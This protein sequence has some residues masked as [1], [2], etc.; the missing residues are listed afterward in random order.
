MMRHKIE[1]FRV[2]FDNS[3]V[4][5]CVL[6]MLRD[7]NNEPCD[8][9]F[10][11]LNRALAELEGVAY[12][13]L[14]GHRFYEVFKNADRK[15]L[16]FYAQAACGG[17]THSMKDYSPEIK[18]YLTVLSYPVREDYCAS[19]LSDDTAYE[20]HLEH[21]NER[22]AFIINDS[23]IYPFECDLITNTLYN[24]K[25]TAKIEG[26]A[27]TV[28][29]FPEAF[30]ARY[31]HPDSAA[32]YRRLYEDMKNGL[33]FSQA[34]I[35]YVFGSKEDTMI[36]R[37]RNSFDRA[38]RPVR[39]YGTAQSISAITEMDRQY[40]IALRQHHINS[41]VID[42]K[43]NIITSGAAVSSDTNGDCIPTPDSLEALGIKWGILRDDRQ[44]FIEAYKRLLNG[45]NNV[46]IRLRR[47]KDESD[48]IDWY[49]IYFDAV[50]DEDG[51]LSKVYASS[52]NINRQ[53]ENE[54]NYAEFEN[55][56]RI[57]TKNTIA[58]I[59][60]NL[61]ANT[62]YQSFAGDSA[63]LYDGT[64]GSA[65]E[66]FEYVNRIAGH[67]LQ[68]RFSRAAMLELYTKGFTARENEMLFQFG[69]SGRRFVRAVTELMENPYTHEVEALMYAIDINRE[70]R[71]QTVMD[72]LVQSDYEFIGIL[73]TTDGLLTIIGKDS[74]K[75]GTGT[76]NAV[77]DYNEN[78]PK[79][80]DW[81][82]RSEEREQAYA[83]LR[84]ENVLEK[85]ELERSYSCAFLGRSQSG[86][87][88]IMW[89]FMYLDEDRK[90]VMITRQDIT[91]AFKL[92]NEQHERL[93]RA[94]DEAQRATRAKTEF[95]SRMS[96][97]IRTPMNAI[98]NLADLAKDDISNQAKLRSDLDKIRL[99]GDFLLGL[100]NDILDMSRIENGKLT[101]TPCVYPVE[102]F[103]GYMESVMTPLFAARN[104]NFV[105]IK[106]NVIPALY[107]DE[108]RF[109]QVF[110]NL[111]S[112]AAKYT[113]EGGTVTFRVNPVKFDEK[114]Y[115][116]QYIVAD[117]GIG[118][119]R[120]FLERAFQPFSQAEST[121][122]Y[123]GTGLGLSI[124]KAIIDAL[125]GDIKIESELGR[126][127]TVYVTLDLP[128][129]D[130]REMQAAQNDAAAKPAA[131]TQGRL[132]GRVLVAEDHQLNRE[133]I[134]RLFSKLGLEAVCVENG[135][136]ALDMLGGN[137]KGYFD[138][139]LMDVRMP[140]M[141]GIAATKKIRAL[142]DEDISGIPIVA[143]T[144]DA[145]S[146]DRNRCMEAGMD[147]Y[148][149]KPVDLKKL[150]EV[151]ERIIAG[152][153]ARAAKGE[154]GRE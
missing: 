48:A 36:V 119:S 130:A 47:Q 85:L 134:V 139:I 135:A 142:H 104:I 45:E 144:A 23:H 56:Q 131:E 26:M 88:R 83:A 137:P 65:D 154:K 6:H 41:W 148:L 108:V 114:H 10:V 117:N 74:Q 151:A 93:Q 82:V 35:R 22:L 12:E 39:A 5:F 53:V 120:D 49:A 78:L 25:F 94:L 77:I 46:S 15:W 29:D 149:A 67:T 136:Q 8:F 109:N 90:D 59:R 68:S 124:T 64:F 2:C 30:I 17:K 145:F 125:G 118:M 97:D 89:K 121:S 24:E 18:K 152:K 44:I 3:P 101:L 21:E 4:P 60:L 71:L 69:G 103:E 1:E 40:H 146:E 111:L 16:A 115:C 123:I 34:N 57:V 129:P 58:S 95:L 19:M 70:K 33:A 55:L 87:K 14:D 50:F 66:F 84:I 140:V 31:V 112:N 11:Y 72:K 91:D 102:R 127:T 20:L 99:S 80:V 143:M 147:D 100:I 141:D 75:V 28:E 37:M 62:C 73:N 122:A 54:K 43:N 86:I 27:L 38:G 106:N 153:T 132:C 52:V 113:P 61:T 81:L 42:V 9:E 32:E 110:F 116:A 105:W 51:S 150:H 138:F 79:A 128:I 126:G 63:D 92:E 96:H 98:I 13:K 107:V 133:I 76:S 7:E